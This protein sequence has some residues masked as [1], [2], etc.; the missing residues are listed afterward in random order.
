MLLNVLANNPG[1]GEVLLWLVIILVFFGLIV[2]IIIFV[3]KKAPMFKNGEQAPT[4]EQ[5]AKEEL[6]RLLVP[7]EDEETIEEINKVEE[8][9]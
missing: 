8:K 5:A 2:G 3:K 7:I 6:D 4:E 9:K 1:I